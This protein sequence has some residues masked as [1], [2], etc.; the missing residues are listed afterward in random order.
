MAV[1]HELGTDGGPD[2]D[3]AFRL[4]AKAVVEDAPG[5]PTRIPSCINADPNAAGH[6]THDSARHTAELQL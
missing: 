1:G 6:A 2:G 4:Q 3:V 5:G